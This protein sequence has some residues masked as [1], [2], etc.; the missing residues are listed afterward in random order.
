MQI[1]ETNT[2]N[3]EQ[4]KISSEYAII[5]IRASL[6]AKN[7]AEADKDGKIS[8]FLNSCG[9]KGIELLKQIKDLAKYLEETRKQI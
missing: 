8:N 5:A 3:E 2:I 6:V 4:L 9:E 7:F 1:E